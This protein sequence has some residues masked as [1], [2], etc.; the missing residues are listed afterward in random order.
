MHNFSVY[1]SEHGGAVDW[2]PLKDVPLL[3]KTEKLHMIG[4]GQHVTVIGSIFIYIVSQ[5]YKLPN[6]RSHELGSVQAQVGDPEDETDEMSDE[7]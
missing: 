1:P 6:A 3:T 2:H 4:M 5:T 7:D